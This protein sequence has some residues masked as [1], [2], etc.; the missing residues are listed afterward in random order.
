MMTPVSILLTI[1]AAMLKPSLPPKTSPRAVAHTVL[2]RCVKEGAYADRALST[3]LDGASERMS[4]PDRALAT[5]LV[6]GVLRH[7]LGLDYFI[8]QLANITERTA[9]PTRVALRLGTYELLH[10]RT[11][12]HAAVDQAVSLVSSASQRRFVNGVLRNMARRRASLT[13]PA[14]EKALTPLT[15]LAI[16]TSSPEWLLRE[17]QTDDLL[18]TFEEVSEWARATQRRPQLAL[19]VNRRRASRAELARRLSEAGAKVLLDGQ[20]ER[21]FPSLDGTVLVEA[22]AGEIPQLPGFASGAFS[23][24]DIGAQC[25]GLLAAP[26][27]GAVVLDLCAA[28]G[29]KTCHLAELLNG[30][31]NVLSIELHRRKTELIKEACERL[32][33]EN[34]EVVCADATDADLLRSKLPSRGADT[35]VLDAPCSGMG[36]LRRNPEHRYR[37]M[38]AAQGRLDGL[39]SV[40]DRLLDSAASCVREGGSLTFSVCSPLARE[41]TE[42]VAAFLERQRGRFEV[43]PIDDAQLLPFA[44]DSEL[45]GGERTCLRTW[46][47]RHP[48]DSH[49]ACKLR[50]TAQL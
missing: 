3:A 47:H 18:P 16:E 14:D 9:A 12:D 6:Y 37:A 2:L 17:L 1:S 48:A 31:G 36:T 44:A 46:T 21:S 35:V 26:A 29:G 39:C 4:G 49:F 25:V 33:L 20:E 22:G 34:V 8:G 42:R 5:E 45:L 50:R 24:Q 27:D 43:L 30:S 7:T 38:D 10:L 32:G 28:P 13:Q 15:A 11:P 23:V 41:T 19:R 40:Q